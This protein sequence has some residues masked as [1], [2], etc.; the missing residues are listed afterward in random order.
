M[1]GSQVPARPSGHP[2]TELLPSEPSPEPAPRRGVILVVDDSDD[3]RQGLAQLLE[4]YGF[5]VADAGTGAEA[6]R[7]LAADPDGYALILLDLLLPGG[8]S[9]QDI[10][11]HQ[12]ADPT[13][14]AIPTI[15]VTVC[16]VSDAER[17][18]LRPDAWIEKPYRFEALLEVVRRYVVSEGSA[19]Q[20]DS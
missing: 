4:L 2:L 17:T 8:I 14:A 10:R 1:I 3:V 15:V 5:L 13:L 19:L 7:H 6:L 9:G 18:I 16:E 11:A 12:L 20:A